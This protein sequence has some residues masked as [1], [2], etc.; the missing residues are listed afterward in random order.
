M[1]SWFVLPVVG[2]YDREESTL[3]NKHRRTNSKAWRQPS[4]ARQSD[5]V[6]ARRSSIEAL[7]RELRA[8]Q[9]CTTPRA[10]CATL[11]VL[12]QHRT[13][14]HCL[15]RARSSRLARCRKRLGELSD[16]LAAG[17]HDA[18]RRL[19]DDTRWPSVRARCHLSA[20]VA[21]FC[22]D[23]RGGRRGVS[24][25]GHAAACDASRHGRVRSQSW[26]SRLR[27]ARPGCA[28]LLVPSH[29]F[30]ADFRVPRSDVLLEAAQ[31][32][33]SV[34][35]Y[36]AVGR[37][38]TAHT[39]PACS[40]EHRVNAFSRVRAITLDAYIVRQ[41]V[42]PRMQ[43]LVRTTTFWRA[44]LRV[45]IYRSRT[46]SRTLSFHAASSPPQPP[47]RLRRPP[48][49]TPSAASSGRS[50]RR[51]GPCCVTHHHTMLPR[52]QNTSRHRSGQPAL[53]GGPSPSRRA[54][55]RATR[56]GR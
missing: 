35:R 34:T 19:H 15:L 45:R 40:K 42:L 56:R 22:G 52:E 20:G 31:K 9:G 18:I 51:T 38:G 36:Q 1:L 41:M 49:C 10:T 30:S 44:H 5:D 54:A 14:W 46:I 2:M 39:L 17:P 8:A 55:V 7:G 26:P 43:C 53:H 25:G 12:P 4:T 24:R 23:G 33:A 3:F 50:C 28:L 21:P 47:M 16:S 29:Y 32:R 11:A 48:T 13:C 27:Y 37:R 6:D